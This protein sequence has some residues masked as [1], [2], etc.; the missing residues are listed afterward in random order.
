MMIGSAGLITRQDLP[1][2][3]LIAK[4]RN[5]HKVKTIRSQIEA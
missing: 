3:L 1:R 5:R 4:M 2:Y